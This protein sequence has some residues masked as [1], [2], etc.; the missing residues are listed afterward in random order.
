MTANQV[1][2]VDISPFE[3]DCQ[4]SINIYLFKRQVGRLMFNSCTDGSGQ[5]DW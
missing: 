3:R 2:F 4:C 5:R 1:F